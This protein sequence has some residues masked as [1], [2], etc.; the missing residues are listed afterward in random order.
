MCKHAVTVTHSTPSSPPLSPLFRFCLCHGSIGFTR[1]MADGWYCSL[2]EWIQ[3]EGSSRPCLWMHVS[4]RNPLAVPLPLN[5]WYICTLE[6]CCLF[7]Y[8]SHYFCGTLYYV[9][10]TW[11][12]SLKVMC[13]VVH[14]TCSHWSTIGSRKVH[15]CMLWSV[16]VCV[17]VCVC[18]HMIQ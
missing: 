11:W 15:A 17:C 13:C 12:L 16:C 1:N 6:F 4:R 9:L 5:R 10:I 3:E 2:W 8:F 14:S 18:V 7:L